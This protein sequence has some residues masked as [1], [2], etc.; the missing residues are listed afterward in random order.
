[1]TLSPPSI[2]PES[3]SASLPV[4]VAPFIVESGIFG[5]GDGSWGRDEFKKAPLSGVNPNLTRNL[6]LSY[7]IIKVVT[8]IVYIVYNLISRIECDQYVNNRCGN[9]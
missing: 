3:K 6:S 7:C 2:T 9:S 1:M 8:C 4:F 5:H